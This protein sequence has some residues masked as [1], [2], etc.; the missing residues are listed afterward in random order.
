MKK[1][2][3]TQDALKKDFLSPL[4][5]SL[6][7]PDFLQRFIPF[8]IP[9]FDR[10]KALEHSWENAFELAMHSDHIEN[11]LQITLTHFWS[12]DSLYQ[13]PSLFLNCTVVNTGQ[14]AIISNLKLNYHDFDDVIDLNEVIG[15]SISLSTAMSLSARFPYI[16]PSAYIQRPDGSYW[17]SIADGAYFDNSGIL[18]ALEIIDIINKVNKQSND[19]VYFEPHLIVISN[20]VEY[21]DSNKYNEL[22]EPLLTVLNRTFGGAIGYARARVHREMNPNN[23]VELSLNTPSAQVPLGWYLSEPSIDVMNKRIQ[24][25]LNQQYAHFKRL[26]K[27]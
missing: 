17:G 21:Y 1:L 22:N 9:A 8:K 24:V 7:F 5:A 18:T 19:N 15:K 23:I 16:T 12:D 11:P 14:R 26:V 27:K 20:Y 25:V 10:A 13:I 2:P 6:I 3:Y 4:T